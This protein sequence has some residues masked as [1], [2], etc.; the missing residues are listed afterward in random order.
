MKKWEGQ[1][2][3]LGGSR[4]AGWLLGAADFGIRLHHMNLL[5]SVNKLA[6]TRNPDSVLHEQCTLRRRFAAAYYVLYPL[7][8]LAKM[9]VLGRM[10]H[11][12]KSGSSLRL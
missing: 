9:T 3:S 5:H 12:T 2:A 8:L 10:Q 1:V 4:F 11:F 6:S 7:T